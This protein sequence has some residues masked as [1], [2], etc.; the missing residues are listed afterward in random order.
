MISLTEAESEPITTIAAN[1]AKPSIGKTGVHLHYHKHHEYKKLIHEQRRELSEWRQNNP[2]AHKPSYIKQPHGPDK[3]MWSKQISTLVSKQVAAKIQ[4]LNKSTHVDTTLTAQKAAA[5]DEQYL[6]SVVQSAVAK[7]FTT[8]PINPSNSQPSNWKAII[9]QA[10]NKLNKSTLWCL[11]VSTLYS[12]ERRMEL[13]PDWNKHW[14]PGC[15]M[16]I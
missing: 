4:K 9:E 2:D 10:H 11:A 1:D 7:H 14:D 8:P 5:N 15:I 6:M 16:G 13:K 12:L 3:S